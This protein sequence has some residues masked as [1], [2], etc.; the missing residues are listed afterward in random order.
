[1]YIFLRGAAEGPG[2]FKWLERLEHLQAVREIYSRSIGA[3]LVM[4]ALNQKQG[5]GLKKKICSMGVQGDTH[6]CVNSH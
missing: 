1:M 4:K 2:A 3:V 6:V 5:K